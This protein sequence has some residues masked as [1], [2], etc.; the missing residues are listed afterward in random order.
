MGMLFIRKSLKIFLIVSVLLLALALNASAAGFVV[1]DVYYEKADSS[2]VVRIDYT[3]ALED[4][5]AFSNPDSTLYDATVDVVRNTIGIFKT[6]WV[7][8]II[9]GEEVVIDHSAAL[10][11]GLSLEQSVLDEVYHVNE[12]EY[13][14]ELVI[15]GGVAVEK[16]VGE[17][18]LID[19]I[20]VVYDELGEQWLVYITLND[21]GDLPAGYSVA[22]VDRVIVKGE[23]A[24]VI[25]NTGNT[26]WQ[27]QIEEEI[28]FWEDDPEVNEDDVTI[29]M[30]DGTEYTLGS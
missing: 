26:T 3:K 5:S 6:V 16:P 15:E 29:V 23:G 18:N 27:L 10:Q 25:P 4:A 28:K 30:N 9:D 2:G 21:D 1:T 24:L 17:L 22:E 8:V 14:Y 11:A 12:P 7:K 19:D 20:V 13:S